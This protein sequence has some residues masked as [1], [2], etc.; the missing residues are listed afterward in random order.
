[1]PIPDSDCAAY[2][3]R[4]EDELAHGI[5]VGA[6]HA[7]TLAARVAAFEA[8]MLAV[9]RSMDAAVAAGEVAVIEKRAMVKKT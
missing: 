1:M 8:A 5:R 2:D 3:K 9:E 6:T 7:P 4:V